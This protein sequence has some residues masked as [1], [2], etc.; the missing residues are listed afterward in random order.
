MSG[1]RVT[2]TGLIS[3][4]GGI[5]SIFTGIIF[6][7][8]VTRSVTPEEYGTWGLIVGLI[9]YVMLI[10]PI[11]SYWSTRDTAR[12]IQSGKTAIW[13]SMLIS[14]GAIS[15]Y[16]LISYLMSDYTN[17]EKNVLL[18]AATLI[19]VLFLTQILTAI[20]LGWKPHVVSYSTIA[21]GISSIP[22]ALFLIYYLNFGVT[23]IIISIFLAN[24]VCI[25][26]LFYYAKEKI[27]NRFNKVFLKKWLKFSWIPIYPGIAILVAGFD[28][29]IFT[30]ITGSVIGLAF[31]TAAMVFP[32]MIS[33]T[34]LISRA[35]YAKLLEEKTKEF[36]SENLTLVFYF[37]ILL[38]SL[39]ITFARPGLYALNPIYEIAFPVAIILSFEIFLSVFTNIFLL[40]LAGVERVDKFEN[41]T[42]KDYI[43]SK[44]FFPQTIRLIQTSIYVLILAIGLLI[45]VGFGRSDQELLL[46]WASIALVT[47]IPLV[48]ILYYFVQK[49]IAIKIEISRIAKF[50]LTAIGV[51]GLTYVLTTQFL[52]YSPDIISFI[53]NVLMF[54]SLGVGLYI[55][56][57][58]LIDNKIRSLVHAIIYEIKIKKP[59]K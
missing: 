52:V 2:Y 32:A 3:L 41:S 11:V 18:F 24:I 6:T 59:K 29:S 51:F 20:N 26:I 1:I 50:S 54:G 23:G 55:I 28:I 14:I 5:I 17:V 25:I 12:N 47:Q 58:Y 19:P 45:L 42:F 9:T 48:C 49:S 21:Y 33:H 8:I 39:V 57:T 53:P 35:I 37:G 36:M 13:S 46:F 43:K 22:L 56:I 34:G 4:I 16:I 44:L 40:A 38:T 7:L 10:G 30:I 15:I 31:W 27:V